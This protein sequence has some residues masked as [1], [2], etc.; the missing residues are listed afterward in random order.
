MMIM[1]WRCGSVISDFGIR[2][3]YG[4]GQRLRQTGSD[5]GSTVNNG[6]VGQS[7]FS[8][9]DDSGVILG[10]GLTGFGSVK[11]S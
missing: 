6:W 8:Q 2:D 5:F 11:P 10:F 3:C 9:Q 7:R 1:A 4:S